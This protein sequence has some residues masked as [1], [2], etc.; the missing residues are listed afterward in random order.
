[1]KTAII[2]HGM[3]SRE[4]YFGSEGTNQSGK[5]WLGWLKS[6]LIKTGVVAG[7]P[8]MPEPYEPDYD[9]WRV[10]FEQSLIDKNT[11]LIGHSIGAGFLVRW[12]SENKVKVGRVVLVAPWLDPNHELKNGFFDFTIDKDFIER[13]DGVT[14]FVSLDDD[15]EIL[16]SVERIKK[17]IPRVSV[18]EFLNQGHF[19]YRSMGTHEFP[20]LLEILIK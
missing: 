18:R 1:M 13:T 11:V 2:L 19:T 17:D 7:V 16:E 15:Q 8:E 4:E 5:H 9:K 3:P 6:N 14:V 10:V 20:E 12:L